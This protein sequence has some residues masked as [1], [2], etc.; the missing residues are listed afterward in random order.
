MGHIGYK[1]ESKYIYKRRSNL[2]C[3]CTGG[4]IVQH[5]NKVFL[6]D[7][8]LSMSKYLFKLPL[9]LPYIIAC[10]L[11]ILERLFRLEIRDGIVNDNKFVFSL[12]GQMYCFDMSKQKLACVGKHRNGMRA[13]LKYT[14]IPGMSGFHEQV[15][16]GEY[17][18]NDDREEV[19][20]WASNDM[21]TWKKVY[22][23][24]KNTI[25][26]IHGIVPD[27]YNN[28]VYIMSGDYDNESA[29]WIAKNN[30]E[31]V[32]KMVGGAQKYR[33]C[34][35]QALPKE[36]RYVTDSEYEENKLY[37]L[38]SKNK[39][40]KLSELASIEGSV[41]YGDANEQYFVFSTTVEPDKGGIK[42]KEC[43]VYRCDARGK[44]EGLL[45]MQKDWLPMKLF[46]YG[47]VK[48]AIN[49][50]TAYLTVCGLKKHDGKL[51]KIELGD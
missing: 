29:I 21:K 41:I 38:K 51:I 25:R 32:E 24:P 6:M 10:R 3:F 39:E 9:G 7:N 12:K 27:I 47:Y 50:D 28:C 45:C 46:Q 1:K 34:Q 40:I 18:S 31:H 33:T 11:R 30:F 35:M 4:L 22:R 5:Y 13:P 26:H 48:I 19:F 36:I 42:S 23:F 2:I 44:L 17:F 43:H 16:Y 15:C 49:T 8:E 20:I 37:S 14:H